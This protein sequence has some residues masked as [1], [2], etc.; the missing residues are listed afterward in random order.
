MPYNSSSA[1]FAPDGGAFA[2]Y[3]SLQEG[4]QYLGLTTAQ[5]T[6]T[7]VFTNISVGTTATLISA[8]S[9]KK[10]LTLVVPSD[11]QAVI[12]DNMA[13]GFSMPPGQYFSP[14][15]W[16]NPLNETFVPPAS[17]FIIPPGQSI[18]LT[19]YNDALYAIVG[20]PANSPIFYVA[21]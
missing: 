4:T 3:P 14:Y 13:T 1:T 16:A 7:G 5:L 2:P 10:S 18:V 19:P 21:T 15:Q 20:G 6:A 12:V 8:A 17:G 11:G 9:V